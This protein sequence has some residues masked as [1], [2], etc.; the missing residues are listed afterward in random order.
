[1]KVVAVCDE[2]EEKAEAAARHWGVGAHYTDIEA[3]LRKEQLR[4]LSV[5][6]PPLTHT[7]IVCKALESDVNVVCEKPLAMTTVDVERMMGR[8]RAGTAK[9]TMICNELYNPAILRAGKILESLHQ[10]PKLVEVQFLRPANDKL[11]RPEHWS[12]SIPGG[13][14]SETLIHGIYLIRHFLGDLTPRDVHLSKQRDHEWKWDEMRASLGSNEKEGVVHISF[15]SPYRQNLMDLYGEENG[16]RADF[17]NSDVFLLRNAE[18][19]YSAKAAE[20]WTQTSVAMENALGILRDAALYHFNKI[21][22]SHEA[23]IRSFVNSVLNGV[24]PPVSLAD[25]HAMVNTQQQITDSI[26][27]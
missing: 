16:V 27:A 3:M 7:D 12:H 14:F 6:T 21:H 1:M 15:N 22:T 4:F 24:P 8:V 23:N 26:D 2:I 5:C 18:R 20:V 9:L 11:L 13:M 19:R 10:Q 17:F 25:V